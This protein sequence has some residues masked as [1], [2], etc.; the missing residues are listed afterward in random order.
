MAAA[1]RLEQ[2]LVDLKSDKVKSRKVQPRSQ[3]WLPP[4]AATAATLPSGPPAS[5]LPLD[6]ELAQPCL[7]RRRSST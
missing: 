5:S 6:I 7:S 2:L 4:A 3:L 1:G